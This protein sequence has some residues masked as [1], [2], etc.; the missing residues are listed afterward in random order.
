MP[1]KRGVYQRYEVV[2]R[3][4]DPL[5]EAM[6]KYKGK[7][8]N[9]INT[10]LKELLWKH[11][12]HALEQAVTVTENTPEDAT[13]PF[14]EQI[15]QLVEEAEALRKENATLRDQIE[16]VR[17]HNEEA[18]NIVKGISAAAELVKEYEIEIIVARLQDKEAEIKRLAPWQIIASRVLSAELIFLKAE[19]ER[20]EVAKYRRLLPE[21]NLV[22]EPHS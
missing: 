9:S 7:A 20:K 5:F 11:F 16:S 8:E 19:L 13:E 1:S 10:L 2:I 3:K 15:L 17:R 14:T 12:F 21:V 4:D 22:T 18:A 6:E